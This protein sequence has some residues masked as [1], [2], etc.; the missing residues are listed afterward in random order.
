M[1]R[2]DERWHGTVCA[3]QSGIRVLRAPQ[4]LRETSK[5]VAGIEAGLTSVNQPSTRT[6]S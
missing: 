4:E 6:T 1:H 2:T 3:G 5:D